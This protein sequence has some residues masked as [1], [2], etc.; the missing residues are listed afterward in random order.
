MNNIVLEIILFI[1]SMTIVLGSFLM[2]TIGISDFIKNI[3]KDIKNYKTKKLNNKII[4][5]EK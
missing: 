4:K 3:A 2:L 1:F 5:N